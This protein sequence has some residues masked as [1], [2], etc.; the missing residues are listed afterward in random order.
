MM[1]SRLSIR[2]RLVGISI[3]FLVPIALQVYLFVEQSRKD[4]TFSDKEVAGV[5]YLRSAWPVLHTLAAAVSDPSLR[6]AANLQSAPKLETASRTYDGQMGS[7]EASRELGKALAAIGWPHQ[8]IGAGDKADAAIAAARA[9]INKIGDASNLILDPDLDSYYVM[10]I[11]LLRMPEVLDQA[12]ILMTLSATYKARKALNDD[13]KAQIPIR[14]GQ[15]AAAVDGIASSL[16]SAYKA[17]GD[18]KT[19]PALSADA[20]RF[21]KAAADYLAA[22]NAAAV[23][24]RDDDRSKLDLTGLKRL[25]DGVFEVADKFWSASANELERLLVARIDGFKAKLWIALAIT[26]AATLLALLFAWSLSRSIIHAIRGLVA[27]VGELTERDMNAAVPHADGRDE[28]GDVARAIAKF[29]DHTIGELTSANSTERAE[30][31]RRTQ[32]EALAGIAEV[33]RGSVATIASRLMQSA[34]VMRSS[35]STVTANAKRTRDQITSVVEDLNATAGNIKLVTGA[36]HELANSIGEISSQ[37]TQVTQVTDDATLRSAEAEKR[38]QGLAANTQQIGEIAGLIASIADQT[39][40]LALNATIEA[41]R[42]GEAGRGFAVVAQEVKALATQTGKATEEIDRQVTAIRE[43]SGHMIKSVH[44]ITQTIA[45]INGITTSIAGAVE[46]QNAATSQIS[47]SLER[48]SIGTE[49]VTAAVSEIPR[50]AAE[51]G[52]VAE[53]LDTLARDLA[54]DADGLQRSVDSL[55]AKLAA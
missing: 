46:Q 5:G 15:F 19:K 23:V 6:P 17:N 13:E 27:G 36:V 18:G 50:T 11:A 21:A 8:A 49:H 24:L 48:A 54:T 9:L 33:V 3:L 44:E 26:L 22:I 38:A 51:T 7:G 37:A 28:I 20:A 52:N 42:A 43:A 47:E 39:N 10:D 4:I 16:E 30:A 53:R 31:I 32:R 55:L 35:T 25:S 45:N 40:L 1:L 41:A 34:Q 2:A 29:R 14:A 12:R